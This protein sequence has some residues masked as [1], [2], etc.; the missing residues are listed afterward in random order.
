VVVDI[1]SKEED[2][3]IFGDGCHRATA[4]DYMLNYESKIPF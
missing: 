4:I 3:L 1:V 2:W